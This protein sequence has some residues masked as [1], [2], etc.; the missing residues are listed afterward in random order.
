MTPTINPNDIQDMSD[1]QESE[2]LAKIKQV[3]EYRKAQDAELRTVIEA[4]VEKKVAHCIIECNPG[5]ELHSVFVDANYEY[6]DEGYCPD[7][8][9]VW[10]NDHN[11]SYYDNECFSLFQEKL[12]KSLGSIS[13]MIHGVFKFDVD[14]LKEKYGIEEPQKVKN[15]VGKISKR[16][17]I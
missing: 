3:F 6:N 10:L 4:F 8:V 11:N 17:K 7:N 13:E 9:M 2:A 14:T 1:I 5:A 15:T 12:D 16:Y